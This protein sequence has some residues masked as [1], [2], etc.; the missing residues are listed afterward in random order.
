MLYCVYCISYNTV[1]GFRSYSHALSNKVRKA[2]LNSHTVCDAGR[3][4]IAPGSQTVLCI[5]PG[6]RN[7]TCMMWKSLLVARGSHFPWVISIVLSGYFGTTTK[8][9]DYPAILIFRCSD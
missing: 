4:Q 1:Y 2:G 9:V 6:K 5:G 3:T 7:G 8:F